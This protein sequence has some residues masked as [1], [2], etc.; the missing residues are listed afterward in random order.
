MLPIFL[1][2]VSLRGSLNFAVKKVT[3]IV[4][5]LIFW[6]GGKSNGILIITGGLDRGD[7]GFVGDTSLAALDRRVF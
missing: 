3:L 1:A 5:D 7:I 2:P 4:N 6:Y